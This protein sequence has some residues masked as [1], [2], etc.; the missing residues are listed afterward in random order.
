[1]FLVVK[2]VR[3]WVENTQREG[4][5]LGQLNV[6]LILQRSIRVASTKRLGTIV[7]NKFQCKVRW[8]HLQIDLRVLDDNPKRRKKC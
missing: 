8:C 7:A 5:M 1:M 6:S 4:L 2:M 3:K